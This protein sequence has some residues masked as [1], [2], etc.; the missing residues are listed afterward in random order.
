VLFVLFAYA[1]TGCGDAS[2]QARDE[3]I[4][5]LERRVT[6][7][8]R[9]LGGE[10]KVEP[11]NRRRGKGAKTDADG[12]PPK[13]KAKGKPKGKASPEVAVSVTSATDVEVY[14]LRQ[15]RKTELPAE[16]AEGEYTVMAMFEGS[17][18]AVEA[19]LIE[20]VRDTPTVIVCDIAEKTC[21]AR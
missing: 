6:S 13:G 16:V 11:G 3:K 1:M 18:V 17:Q 12:A 5:A 2:D 20:V 15:R 14:L 4:E 8:E 19:G 9:R 21:A 10:E 7:L